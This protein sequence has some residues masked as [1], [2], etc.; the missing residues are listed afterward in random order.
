MSLHLILITFL[1]LNYQKMITLLSKK[2]SDCHCICLVSFFSHV[3][4]EF[5][6][7]NDFKRQSILCLTMKGMYEIP[8]NSWN[9]E[10]TTISSRSWSCLSDKIVILS[11]ITTNGDSTEHLWTLAVPLF[12]RLMYSCAERKSKKKLQR[13]LLFVS[14]F[15]WLIFGS[16]HIYESSAIVYLTHWYIL[17]G[18]GGSVLE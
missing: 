17:A 16:I 6:S 10:M 8:G 3:F 12:W 18:I 14:C 1:W 7:Q 9:V 5:L 11:I 15:Q 4:L 13:S 2:R